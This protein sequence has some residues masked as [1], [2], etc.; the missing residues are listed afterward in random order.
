MRYWWWTRVGPTTPPGVG[1]CEFPS[2][3]VRTKPELARIMLERA[4]DAG[5]P[6]SWVTADE[7]SGGSPALR[8]WLEERQ[9][10]YVQAV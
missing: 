8:E 4:L 1:P 6:A 9:V 10:P 5:V 3:W 2:R 7:V